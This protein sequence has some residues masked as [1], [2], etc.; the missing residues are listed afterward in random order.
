MTEDNKSTN[1][2]RPVET[3][4][5]KDFLIEFLK[6]TKDWD[7]HSIEKEYIVSA[8]KAADIVKLINNMRVSISRIRNLYRASNKKVPPFRFTS[9]ITKLTEEPN[10]NGYF[11]YS[12]KLGKA[13]STASIN[14]GIIEELL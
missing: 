10:Q 3:I 11:N 7:N 4:R 2:V 9:S 14:R 13:N 5:T 1:F 6:D 12:I 8:R